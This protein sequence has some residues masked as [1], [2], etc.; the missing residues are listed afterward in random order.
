MEFAKGEPL[1]WLPG[2]KIVQPMLLRSTCGNR[3]SIM[4]APGLLRWLFIDL[5]PVSGIGS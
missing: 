4:H 5:S 2:D 3:I 1:P